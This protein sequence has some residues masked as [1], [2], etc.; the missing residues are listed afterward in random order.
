MSERTGLILIHLLLFVAQ[1]AT[2]ALAI[3]VQPELSALSV[4]IGAA[5]SFFPNPFK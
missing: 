4:P 1:I 3:V 2:V 5:Q